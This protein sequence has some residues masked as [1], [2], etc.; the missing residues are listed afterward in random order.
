MSCSPSCCS[1]GPSAAAG[2]LKKKLA[3][4]VALVTGGNSGIGLATVQRFVAEDATQVYITGRR[5]PALETA[6]KTIGQ[7]VTAVRSDMSN[8]AD[9]DALYAMITQPTIR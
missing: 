6:V 8:L 7:R 5:Q 2:S 4:K 1:I 3:G 9:L